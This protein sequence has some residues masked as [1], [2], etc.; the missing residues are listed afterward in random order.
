M[1]F[2]IKILEIISIIIFLFHSIMIK[3]RLGITA[4]D[5]ENGNGVKIT[6]IDDEDGAAA[7]AGLKENDIIT[8]VNGK[9]INSTDDLRESVKDIKKGDTVKISYKRNNQTQSAEI[10]F[11]KDFKNYRLIIIGILKRAV[12]L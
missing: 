8:Q 2:L 1:I 11:P 7:K 3:P 5:T 6:G 12:Y 9:A 10:K 4:Q